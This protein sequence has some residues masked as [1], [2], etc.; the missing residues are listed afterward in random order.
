LAKEGI[1]SLVDPQAFY[2]EFFLVKELA[3]RQDLLAGRL[4]QGGM[5]PIVARLKA[6]GISPADTTFDGRRK[7]FNDEGK[8]SSG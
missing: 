5:R 6:E 2:G 7:L 3:D 8:P 1:A 4:R